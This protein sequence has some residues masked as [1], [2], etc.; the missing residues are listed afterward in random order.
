LVDI[1]KLNEEYLKKFEGVKVEV[2]YKADDVF[3]PGAHVAVVDVDETG[4]IKVL[5][6]YAVDDV[7]RVLN[8]EEVE[9][10]IVGGVLQGVSQVTLEAMR[11]DERE[12]RCALQLL[13]VEFQLH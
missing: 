6:Y 5:E 13:I 8:A 10:Q 7:G 2:F 4:K 1:D 11:Y 3:A 9:G 12:F